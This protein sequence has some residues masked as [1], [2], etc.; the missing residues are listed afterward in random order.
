MQT[1]SFCPSPKA[2]ISPTFAQSLFVMN[3]KYTL[4][5]AIALA[6]FFSCQEK[7]ETTLK[8]IMTQADFPAPP[9]AEKNP[10]KFNDFGK[11]R[12]DDY[13]WIRSP[14][15]QKTIDYL[16]QENAYTDTVMAHT[17]PLQEKLFAE[18]KARIKEVDQSVPTL[19]NGYWYYN[20]TEEGK[21]YGILCRR[22]VNMQSPEEIMLDYNQIAEGKPTLIAGHV[23]VSP[24]GKLLAFSY[25]LTGSYAEW[26]LYVK[27]LQTGNLL[28][29]GVKNMQ[30]VE[31]ANDSKTL[32]YTLADA[33]L[34][35]DRVFRHEL[36]SKKPDVL[37]FQE[38][39]ELFNVRLSKTRSQAFIK[40][41]CESF[42]TSDVQLIDANKPGTKPLIFTPRKKNVEYIIDH[43]AN[44]FFVMEKDSGHKN[45][46]V[47]EA[48]LNGHED[49]KNWKEIIPHQADTKIMGIYA[50]ES[51][52]V[53]MT[54]MQGLKSIHA[55]NLATGETKTVSFPE[56]VY[57]IYPDNNPN[58]KSNTF[59]YSYSSLNRPYSVFEYDFSTDK[60]TKLK[61][62][63]IPGG[64]NVDNY[65][66]ERIWAKAPD[67]K[68]VPMAVMYKKGLEK[69]GN[70]PTLLYS[71]GSYGAP[72]EADFS[73]SIFSLVDRG[74]VYA[75]ASIRG[76]DDLGEEW[77]EDGKLLKKKNTF[78]DFI[79]CAEHLIA[80]KYTQPSKLAIMGGSAG[81]LLM[82]AVVNMRPDLFQAVLALVPF[83][84]VI[85]TMQDKTIPLTTQ[86]YEQWGNPADKE[87]FDYM[88]SY[89]PY[90]NVEKKNYPNILATGGLY[91]SQVGFHEPTKWVAKLRAMKTDQNLTLLHI[92]MKSGHGGASGR[93]DR[94]KETAFYYAFMLDRLGVE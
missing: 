11:E 72:T 1:P 77:Y 91:D 20:R 71:Y 88:M 69:T 7:K 56:P 61:E 8:T 65:T 54:K 29:D 45:Y 80:Q 86:E 19:E 44:Q 25:N 59:R 60:S 81:G 18:M 74:F 42:T 49:R 16:N 39:N 32:F 13:Y 92:N 64:F 66:V 12:I 89:S 48:P 26:D 5:S 23:T 22:K 94:L 10:T 75:E 68:E 2:K 35:T 46:R 3:F 47:F 90:D 9:V 83:V 17:K 33:T 21:Q 78:T 73:S 40:I 50:F 36:G 51:H 14:K 15:D 82:G 41:N 67:G 93:F 84:D 28:P 6:N 79:A 85:N 87:Y 76:G 53:Y 37:V 43:H 63:E 31:W 58:F 57:V 62:Q 30:S 24:D 38:K 70:N 34:R 4:F 52:L 27:D 55:R